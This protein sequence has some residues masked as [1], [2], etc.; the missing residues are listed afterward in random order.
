MTTRLLALLATLMFATVGCSDAGPSLSERVERTFAAEWAP[1][2]GVAAAALVVEVESGEVVA[3]LVAGDT[4]SAP[5]GGGQRPTGS[6]AKVFVLA[7]LVAAGFALDEPWPY[8][9]CVDV[10]IA[11]A[12]AIEPGTATIVEATARSINPAYVLL[13]DRVGPDRIARA[14]APFG[15]VL[16]PSPAIPLG[17]EP[18]SMEAVA[19]WFLT[20]ARGGRRSSVG[21]S[22]SGEIYLDP[23]Q[24]ATV[25]DVLSG[26][27]AD[28]GTG[29]AAGGPGDRWGKTGTADRRTDAWFAGVVDDSHV[30]VVWVGSADGV[31]TVEP[32]LTAAPLAGGGI[33]ATIFDAIATEIRP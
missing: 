29:A 28:G 19:G 10:V 11:D 8:P 2:A 32:P 24:A 15:A 18:M 13:A 21:S 17:I 25:R 22:E 7:E 31:A 12:C 27:V 23:D 5:L 20:V 4:D 26:V 14:A 30:I 16:Q 6:V 33:P 9:A 3:A 1:R